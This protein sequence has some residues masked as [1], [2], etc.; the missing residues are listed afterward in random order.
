M[1]IE[2]IFFPYYFYIFNRLD[3]TTPNLNHYGSTAEKRKKLVID[4]VAAI[5][6]AAPA[7]IAYGYNC[8]DRERNVQKV[9]ITC[10]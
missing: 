3:D 4:C 6:M 5:E 9:F 7:N 2:A 10:L 8:N 1:V